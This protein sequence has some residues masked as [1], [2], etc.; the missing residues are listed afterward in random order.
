MSEAT[1]P[2][3]TTAVPDAVLKVEG[4][5]IVLSDHRNT[6]RL[7]RQAALELLDLL[8]GLIAQLPDK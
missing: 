4:D 6:L 1:K 2:Q 3:T 5:L 8:P 7:T